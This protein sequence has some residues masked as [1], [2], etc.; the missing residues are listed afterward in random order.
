MIMSSVLSGARAGR[1]FEPMQEVFG[2]CRKTPPGFSAAVSRDFAPLTDAV[3]GSAPSYIVQASR[4]SSGLLT[5]A[6]PTAEII[7]RALEAP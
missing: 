1:G 2:S 5:S 6:L 4:G 3:I 7:E